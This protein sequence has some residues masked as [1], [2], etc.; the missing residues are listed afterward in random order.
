MPAQGL[1]CGFPIGWQEA[2]LCFPPPL[3]PGWKEDRSNLGPHCGRGR[4]HGEARLW[5]S[6]G[7]LR[8]RG[9]E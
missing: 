7:L 8:M 2:P 5:D 9:E 6:S 4:A 1:G 3:R